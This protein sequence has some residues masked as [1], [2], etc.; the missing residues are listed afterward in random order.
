MIKITDKGIELAVKVTPNA[1][2]N[3]IVGWEE[4]RLKVKIAA[5]PEKGEANQEL[6]KFL[7]KWL[8]IPKSQIKLLSGEA[9]RHKRLLIR[10][11]VSFPEIG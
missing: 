3:E 1:R 7:A 10:G 5:V 6:I 4:Q 9:S 2:R 8:L 11:I